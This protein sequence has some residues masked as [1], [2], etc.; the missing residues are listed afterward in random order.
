MEAYSSSFL[1]L[2]P[3][4]EPVRWNEDER[5]KGVYC[6]D[7]L[8]ESLLPESFLQWATLDMP[9]AAAVAAPVSDPH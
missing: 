6:G 1:V 2:A 9:D 3:H 8:P 4:F 5:G 7:A